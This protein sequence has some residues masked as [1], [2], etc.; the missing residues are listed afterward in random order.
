MKPSSGREVGP[1]LHHI[2]EQAG[3]NHGGRML[4]LQDAAPSCHLASLDAER[5]FPVGAGG[6]R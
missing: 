6:S 4:T 3:A 1:Q 5:H 2:E